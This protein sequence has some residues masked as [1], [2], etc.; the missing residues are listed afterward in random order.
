M[1]ND[2]VEAGKDTRVDIRPWSS[3]DCERWS[4]GQ[5]VTDHGELGRSEATK[6]P[7]RWHSKL[8]ASIA[9]AEPGLLN[10]SWS[11]QI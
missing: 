2:A 7:N 3:E 11:Q 8:A 1:R 4:M 6:E 5:H 9:E 10:C